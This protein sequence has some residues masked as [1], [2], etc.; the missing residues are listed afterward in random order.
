MTKERPREQTRGYRS[1]LRVLEAALAVFAERGYEATTFKHIAAEAGMSL[2]LACRYFP[3]KEMLALALYDR[4][5]EQL[6]SWA[7][8]MPEGT[9][10][11]RFEATVQAKLA[12]LEPHRRVLGSLVARALDPEA[13]ESVLGPASA[14]VRSKVSGVFAVAVRGATDAP[15][16]SEA[17][18]LARTLY[19][20]HLGLVLLWTQDRSP[21]GSATRD[22]VKLLGELLTTFG[23][24]FA[25]AGDSPL[26]QRVDTLFGQ[27]LGTARGA[28]PGEAARIVLQ[29]IFRRR[30]VLPGTPPEPSETA[31]ALHLPRVQAS[32]DAAEPLLLVLPAFP[33]KAPNAGKVLG[34]LPDTAEWLALQ[35]LHSLL[36]ELRE[37]HP[38]GAQ[39]VICSD[40]HVFADAVGV[41]DADVAR[42]RAELEKM[43]QELGDEDVRIFGL[44]DA[45][46]D[47]KPAT[48]RRL[49][50]ERYGQSLEEVRERAERSPTHR[51]QLD[52]IHR[53]LVEDELAR[54]TK[55]S[56]SQARK[57][58]RELAYEVVRRSDAWGR[59]VATAFP[60]ALRLSIHPQPDVSEKIGV[61]L[62]PTEDAWLTPW[63]GVA[64]LQGERFRLMKRREA[65]A[66]G[67]V[68]V[69]E[70][71]RPMYM[72]VRG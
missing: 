37:A 12:L 72:E 63:H 55:D 11:A 60:R 18:R 64:V 36:E 57:H 16:P 68:V 49:L 26:G 1:R 38:P 27:L 33:A 10:A 70:D 56:R 39:L 29:R 4:L 42:Y 46:G 32:I 34:P 53:F 21:G 2:G 6:E 25:L 30:R 20:L 59:L 65:E 31:L 5:A 3:V 58:T 28:E 14:V 22:A 51:A 19:G 47:V 69:E 67:A 54:G 23:P 17:G 45:F 35:S 7:P 61:H 13:R 66:A 50:L 71:G 24:M 52:G 43:I 15:P 48:A 41:A 62:L 44:E 40:G 8:E 9:V